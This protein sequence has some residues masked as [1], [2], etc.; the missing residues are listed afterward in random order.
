[1]ALIGDLA[2]AIHLVGVIVAIGAV[3]VTD[4]L[5]LVSKSRPKAMVAV[6]FFSPFLSMIVWGGFALVA[7]SGAVLLALGRGDVTS[8]TFLLKNLFVGI[9]FAN[10]VFLTESISVR[11]EELV[12]DGYRELPAGFEK[13]AAVSATVSVTG[14]WGAMFTAYF[15]VG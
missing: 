13:K 8:S 6:A 2:L 14:W 3:A 11:V 12:G 4:F 5:T 9:A 7:A 1:M 15:L 10:G